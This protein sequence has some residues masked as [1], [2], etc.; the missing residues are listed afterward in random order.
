MESSVDDRKYSNDTRLLR[1]AIL[2]DKI[3][4]EFEDSLVSQLLQVK[5][6]CTYQTGEENKMGAVSKTSWDS[7]SYAL[8]MAHNVWMHL[9]AVQK[10]NDAYTNK[11]MIPK[12]L[13]D[14]RFDRVYFKDIIYSIFE[15]SDRS[16]AEDRIEEWNSFYLRII[17][18][19][20]AVG[21]KTLNSKTGFNEM[22]VE[23]PQ[24][25]TLEDL[26]SDKPKEVLTPIASFNSMFGIEDT[27]TDTV[28][29]EDEYL[30]DQSKADKLDEEHND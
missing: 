9:D 20:G 19:R 24:Y 22:I 18:Q 23:V 2:Q 28:T 7:F 4:P 26:D 12:M 13:I 17:G 30:L 6:I 3:V 11:N 27:K 29:I 5:D 10:A 21:K 15:T 16:V 1:D 8:Q 14:E 25:Q